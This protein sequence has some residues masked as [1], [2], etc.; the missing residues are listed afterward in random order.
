M[1]PAGA[2]H[3]RSAGIFPL[4]TANGS[5][6]NAMALQSKSAARLAR[7]VVRVLSDAQDGG[8][9]SGEARVLVEKHGWPAICRALLQSYAAAAAT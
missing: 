4:T 8:S 2:A 9:L 1:R 7:A 3:R 5:F 6:G